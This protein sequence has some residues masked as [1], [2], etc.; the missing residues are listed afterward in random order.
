MEKKIMRD[1]VLCLSSFYLHP[2]SN[3]MT[4]IVLQNDLNYDVREFISFCQ[5]Y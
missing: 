4:T 1:G 3:Q 2:I 5:S